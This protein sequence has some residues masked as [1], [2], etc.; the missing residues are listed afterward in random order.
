MSPPFKG[1]GP[2][3]R[4]R[5]HG[6]SEFHAEGAIVRI[7]AEGPFNVEGVDE[8]SRKMLALLA[9]IPAGQAVVILAE[10]RGT[11]ISPADAWEVFEVHSRRAQAGSLRILGSAWVLAPDVEGRNFFVPKARQIFAQVGRQ[12][13]L[14]EDVEE[15][16]RWAE[17]L[18]T[19]AA[20]GDSTP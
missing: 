2:E 9:E 17:K 13:E 20:S 12:F 8:F 4:F 19:T 16:K 18:L 10:I 7:S 15:A 3:P 11:L 5:P 14:F 1:D 6:S